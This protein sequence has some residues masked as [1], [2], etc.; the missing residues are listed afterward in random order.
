MIRASALVLVIVAVITLLLTSTSFAFMSLA[1][2]TVKVVNEAGQP[3]DLP[4]VN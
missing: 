3:V 4:P 1:K 2:I